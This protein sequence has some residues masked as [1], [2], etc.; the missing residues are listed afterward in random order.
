MNSLQVIDLTCLNYVIQLNSLFDYKNFAANDILHRILIYI[1]E[2]TMKIIII[3]L[4]KF[5]Y[6]NAKF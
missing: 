4:M 5:L 1:K 2:Y 6:N 3:I